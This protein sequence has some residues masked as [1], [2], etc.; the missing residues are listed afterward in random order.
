MNCCSHITIFLL[1]LASPKSAVA[2][3]NS[4]ISFTSCPGYSSTLKSK[5]YQQLQFTSVSPE[6]LSF[7]VPGKVL[8]S[9]QIQVDELFKQ[10][11]V[12]FIRELRNSKGRRW[13]L[14]A[15]KRRNF[16]LENFLDLRAGHNFPGTFMNPALIT[17]SLIQLHIHS[18]CLE[19]KLWEGLQH[20]N[21][22]FLLS[23]QAT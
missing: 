20:V 8:G 4:S 5:I 2:H 10:K 14:G 21:R 7:G 16:Y 12:H 23:F 18:R 19:R 11:S 1:N 15:V 3:A 22:G 17:Y 9:P 6:L 13:L